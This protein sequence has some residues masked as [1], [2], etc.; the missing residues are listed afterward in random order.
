MTIIEVAINTATV[1]T[2][3]HT[4]IQ[5]YIHIQTHIKT[6]IQ[7]AEEQKY[8]KLSNHG[9]GN[10]FAKVHHCKIRPLCRNAEGLLVTQLTNHKLV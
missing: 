9:T 10:S 2:Y 6:N 5:A 7:Y 4:Y 3:T 8:N 1:H